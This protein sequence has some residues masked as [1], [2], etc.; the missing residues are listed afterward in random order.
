MM[1]NVLITGALGHIGSSLICQLP[2]VIEKVVLVDNL[3]SQRYC[4]LFSAPK[5]RQMI[6]KQLDISE[7]DMI[8]LIKAADVVVHL[9]ARTNAERVEQEFMS[10]NYFATVEIAKL[11]ARFGTKLVFPSTTSVYGF[12][13][14]VVDEDS[15]ADPQSGYAA[16]KLQVE[17]KIKEIPDLNY[18]IFRFGTIV[19]PSPGMRFHTTVN[20]FCWQACTGQPV[21]VWETAYHQ[22]RPYLHL[23]DAVNAI[24][25]AVCYDAF[26]QDLFNVVTEN[27]TV[28]RVIKL[29]EKHVPVR[30]VFVKSGIMNQLSYEV[31]NRKIT[32]HFRFDNF[33]SDGVQDTIAQIGVWR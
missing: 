2:K 3:S 15:P 9:A 14:D 8:E 13:K 31:S 21:T 11:C 17:N 5:G 19:G 20:K 26:D 28:A 29:I 12:S 27:L 25:T 16:S 30:V 22:K 6:F 10:I 33:I 7:V 24:K 4:S 32:K 18:V 1:T 23:Q